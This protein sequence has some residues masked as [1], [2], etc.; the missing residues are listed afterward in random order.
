M[1]RIILLAMAM[2]IPVQSAPKPEVLWDNWYTESKSGSP[3][4]YYN[5][6]VE[7]VGERIKIQVNRWTKKGDQVFPE[8]LGAAV[9]NSPLLEPVLYN[10]RKVENR[11]EISIDGTIQ[12]NGKV[13]SVIVTQGGKPS[14]PLRAEMLPK[15]ILASSFPV[16]IHKNYKRINGVQPI[17]F[18]TIV[19]DQVINQIPILSGTAYE[20]REDEYAKE[21]KTRKLRIEFNDLVAIWWVT[22]KGDADRIQLKA[23]DTE[24]RKVS[25]DAAKN[26]LK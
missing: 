12:K 13:F 5:E 19:E 26:F 10:F 9:K 2:A 16:W 23:L 17:S 24:V 15:L 11:N 18:Q 8:N 21:T 25:I 1:T 4:S 14:A 6:K 20:M 3:H 7:I 22:P